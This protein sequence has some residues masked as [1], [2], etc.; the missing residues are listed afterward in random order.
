MLH[1]YD[2]L[3][4]VQVNDFGEDEPAVRWSWILWFKDSSTCQQRGY[5]WS[6]SCAHTGD[7]LCQYLQG[8]RVHLNPK[9]SKQEQLDRREKWMTLAASQGF[10]EAAF[11]V[12]RSHFGHR[13]LTGAVHWLHAAHDVGEADA[14]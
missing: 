13:N 14:R 4:G 5:E 7:A 9:L 11:K 8:W 10:G 2:L 6:E 3:H 12:G 1:Q